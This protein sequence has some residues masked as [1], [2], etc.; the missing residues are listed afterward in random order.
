MEGGGWRNQFGRLGV[1]RVHSLL[2][3]GNSVSRLAT[4]WLSCSLATVCPTTQCLTYL[5]GQRGLVFYPIFLLFFLSTRKFSV[6]GIVG[7]SEFRKRCKTPFPP[8]HTHT[9]EMCVIPQSASFPYRHYAKF[10]FSWLHIGTQN[11]GFPHFSYF[12]HPNCI[13]YLHIILYIS[14]FVLSPCIWLKT[15]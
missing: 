11:S 14:G 13:G 7:F 4:D 12:A 8:P 3:D 10:F 1:K 5:F 6:R 9:H 2:F 15:N